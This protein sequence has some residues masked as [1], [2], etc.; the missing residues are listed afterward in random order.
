MT[1]NFKKLFYMQGVQLPDKQT[2]RG[3]SRHEG[4][5]Y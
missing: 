1:D 5:Q 4:K 2:L 3:D